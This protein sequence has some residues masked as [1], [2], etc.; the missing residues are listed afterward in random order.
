MRAWRFAPS[1]WRVLV[2]SSCENAP[3]SFG[4]SGSGSGARRT[5]DGVAAVLLGVPVLELLPRAGLDHVARILREQGDVLGGRSESRTSSGTGGTCIGM[6]RRAYCNSCLLASCAHCTE[7]LGRYG[8]CTSRCISCGTYHQILNGSSTASA[9]RRTPHDPRPR[10]LLRNATLL[11]HL[12]IILVIGAVPPHFVQ[13]HNLLLNPCMMAKRRLHIYG[14]A[15]WRNCQYLVRAGSACVRRARSCVRE[16]TY[17]ATRRPECV[18]TGLDTLSSAVQQPLERMGRRLASLVDL[19]LLHRTLVVGL[20]NIGED[21]VVDHMHRYAGRQGCA[22]AASVE[23]R[24]P[25]SS[26]TGSHCSAQRQSCRGHSRSLPGALPQGQVG[27]CAL[28]RA[29]PTHRTSGGCKHCCC[30]RLPRASCRHTRARPPTVPETR[31]R[32]ALP[33]CYCA[34]ANRQSAQA[35]TDGRPTYGSFCC[36]GPRRCW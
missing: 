3:S 8:Y 24:T 4:A 15:A 11:L 1:F 33:P 19:G 26:S 9:T 16:G 34:C 28:L 7:R 20:G 14:K 18:V 27:R 35:P 30:A 29:G 13:R 36:R 12:A 25:A 32:L 10:M 22:H 23:Q 21:T 6:P 17:C 2:F 5:V 31:L